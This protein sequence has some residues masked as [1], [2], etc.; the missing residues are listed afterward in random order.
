MT[1]IEILYNL[2]PYQNFLEELYQKMSKE[3]TSVI[4]KRSLDNQ[5]HFITLKLEYGVNTEYLLQTA[6]KITFE[7]KSNTIHLTEVY[8]EEPT[9]KEPLEKLIKDNKALHETHWR[10]QPNNTWYYDEK[11][12]A[13]LNMADK[14]AAVG[15]SCSAGDNY[16]PGAFSEIKI[17][18]E[19]ILLSQINLLNSRSIDHKDNYH[20]RK[21]HFYI[22]FSRDRAFRKTME[23]ND[24]IGDMYV[25]FSD[26]SSPK[27]KECGQKI[28]EQIL[29][30]K[31]DFVKS[32][33]Q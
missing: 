9:K 12:T 25:V 7:I 24:Q 29:Q 10:T 8:T 19:G 18:E 21:L 28:V 26:R 3:N 4:W 15:E 13:Y 20:M 30:Q 22:P 6:V 2:S 1:A 14:I 32:K 11:V 33:K 23:M 5:Y 16:H 17:Q 27:N 31:E